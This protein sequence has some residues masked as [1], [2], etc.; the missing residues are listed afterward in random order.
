MNPNSEPLIACRVDRI[1]DLRT[2]LALETDPEVRRGLQAEIEGERLD[3]AL[4]FLGE[5]P[6]EPRG[7]DGFSLRR[8]E[9]ATLMLYL[10]HRVLPVNSAYLEH[11][12][13]ELGIAVPAKGVAAVSPTFALDAIEEALSQVVYDLVASQDLRRRLLFYRRIA[14]SFASRGKDEKA[15]A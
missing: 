10:H 1:V 6:K 9:H 14:E 11:R 8:D 5:D 13:D 12:L 7:G 3:L 15:C 4:L 2:R